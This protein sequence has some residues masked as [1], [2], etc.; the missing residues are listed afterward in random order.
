MK[1]AVE[2]NTHISNVVR[3]Y[4]ECWTDRIK[5][6]HNRNSLALHRDYYINSGEDV[7]AAKLRL[8]LLVIKQFDLVN[9]EFKTFVDA[10]CGVG[11]TAIHLALQFPRI[12]FIGVNICPE[13]T[14]LAR[15]FA[16]ERMNGSNNAEFMQADYSNTGIDSNTIDGIYAIESICHAENKARFYKEANRILKLNGKL[17]MLDYF[18]ERETITLNEKKMMG[19]FLGGWEIPHCHENFRLLLKKT[20]FEKIQFTDISKNVRQGI[21][22]SCSKALNQLTSSHNGTPASMEKHLRAC[23]ALNGLF[24]KKIISYRLLT[25]VKV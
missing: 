2:V 4:K 18:L 25:A 22:R 5:R 24:E 1:A 8:N 17:V 20:G 21:E 23:V 9:N 11:G 14:A 10:G 15:K 3:Y 12:H 16:R 13:Q 19:D 6:G 7:E